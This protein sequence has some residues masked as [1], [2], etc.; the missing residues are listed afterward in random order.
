VLLV[1]LGSLP[2]ATNANTNAIVQ[3]TH[4]PGGACGGPKRRG[5]GHLRPGTGHTGGRCRWLQGTGYKGLLYSSVNG[6]GLIS[7]WQAKVAAW[8]AEHKAKTAISGGALSLSLSR[9]GSHCK[10]MRT[11]LS[12][13][14]QAAAKHVAGVAR[15]GVSLAKGVFFCVAPFRYF[16]SLANQHAS[17]VV[18][19]A[20]SAPPPGALFSPYLLCSR[21]QR[22]SSA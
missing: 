16:H 1:L 4:T 2:T 3:A 10:P 15:A 11:A 18:D 5:G 21:N 14:G 22:V 12:L 6:K 17:D 8:A 7:V 20:R 13:P 19:V 9:R